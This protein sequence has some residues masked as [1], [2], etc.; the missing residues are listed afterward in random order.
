[1]HKASQLVVVLAA[2]FITAG[3]QCAVACAL[4]ECTAAA[5]HRTHCHENMPDKTKPACSHP[6]VIVAGEGKVF[7][8]LSKPA[9]ERGPAMVAALTALPVTQDIRAVA[10]A[11]GDNG[12]SPP[13]S[14]FRRFSVLRI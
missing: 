3:T 7:S 13:V 1:V 8:A 6:M 10:Q 12:H 11:R 14:G 5:T 4:D 2:A 9:D